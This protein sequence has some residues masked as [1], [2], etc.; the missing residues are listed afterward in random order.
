MHYFVLYVSMPGCIYVFSMCAG[1][2]RPKGAMRS[3]GANSFL[4]T[5]PYNCQESNGC[6]MEEQ[7]RVLNSRDIS[8]V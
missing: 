4:L 2:H 1:A 3:H 8:P 5:A 7:Q 6:P